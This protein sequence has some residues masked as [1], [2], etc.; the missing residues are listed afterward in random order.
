MLMTKELEKIIPKMYSSEDTK[1]EAKT[2]FAK[3]F[4]HGWTWWILEYSKEDR[5]FFAYVQGMESELGYVSLDELE[6][7][8]VNGLKVERDLHFTQTLYSEIE[9]LKC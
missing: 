3:Y 9:E 7:L 8:E 1:L 6:E 4:L 5:L 2:I